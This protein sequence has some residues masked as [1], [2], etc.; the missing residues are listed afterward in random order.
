MVRLVQL[1]SVTPTMEAAREVD[2]SATTANRISQNRA[3]EQNSRPDDSRHLERCP[4]GL[5]FTD[6]NIFIVAFPFGLLK[7]TA[8]GSHHWTRFVSDR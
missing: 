6:V 1:Q 5:E 7:L 4:C 8:L 2:A 3:M